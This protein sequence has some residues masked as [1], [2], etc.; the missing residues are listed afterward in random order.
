MNAIPENNKNNLS[1]C[2]SVLCIIWFADV[3]DKTMNTHYLENIYF[4]P[5][6]SFIMQLAFVGFSLKI[7]FCPPSLC[8]VS[9]S[10]AWSP[11]NAGAGGWRWQSGRRF[12]SRSRNRI[13][14]REMSGF[15]LEKLPSFKLVLLFLNAIVHS[16]L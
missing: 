11:S 6:D 12:S 14:I 15:R 4:I 13:K 10:L 2:I 9:C 16:K 3:T 7:I 8:A 5:M 1:C